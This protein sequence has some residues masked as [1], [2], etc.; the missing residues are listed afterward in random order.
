MLEREQAESALRE[1]EEKLRSVVEVAY[2]S[3]MTLDLH[4]RI[5]YTNRPPEEL[6]LG[7]LA[8]ASIFDAAK[9]SHHDFLRARLEETIATGENATFE[10]AGLPSGSRE[11]W[12]DCRI[13]PVYRSGE[14]AELTMLLQYV[15]ARKEAEIILH[16]S[17]E[18]L[19]HIVEQRTAALE[20]AVSERERHAIQLH[21]LQRVREEMWKM[22]HTNEIASV[23]AAIREGLQDIDL[24]FDDC[25][26][27]MVNA[28]ADPPIV[29][30]FTIGSEQQLTEY[31]DSHHT[32]IGIWKNGRTVYRS[33]MH[34]EDRLAEH[35]AIES[36]N[37]HPIYSMIDLPFSH[38]T[39]SINSTETEA[40]SPS[41]IAFLEEM[42]QILSEV[43]KRLD[44]M[45]L[46]EQ[47]TLALESEVEERQRAEEELKRSLG[48]KEI[49]LQE[50]HHRVKNNMQI[51]S[52][53]I[54]LQ[55]RQTT[56]EQTLELF[57]DSR[58]RIRSMALVHE[59]LYQ[60][61]DLAR[62]DLPNYIRTLNTDLFFSYTVS[63][64]KIQHRIEVDEIALG[65]DMAIPCGLVINELV[66][67]ALK[68]AFPDDRQGTVL[69]ELRCGEYDSYALAVRDDGI[70]LP[71]DF[72]IR[73]SNSLGMTLV[74]TLVRQ[75]RGE[76]TINRENGT[77]FDIT[78]SQLPS[79]A[80]L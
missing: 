51:V 71:A 74:Q 21:A 28:T 46:M 55:S 24:T 6:N 35:Q 68:Y 52:S 23:L 77:S 15:T 65:I 31:Q 62:I 37:D 76:L 26:I 18:E 72:D 70:G 4:G 7:H 48:D 10:I 34:R 9:E 58:D 75:L 61:N 19:E 36:N 12:F 41:D 2:D 17:R 39:L 47:H 22:Q 73:R 27:N 20:R 49:L 38:G 67:N 25:G 3:I 16:R 44:D 45:R 30:T 32:V 33:N 79:A 64:E 40:F 57:R 59:L 63:N 8:S 42:A 14:I 60:S 80:L 43:F 78:F 13:A 54:D 53:L 69:V 56:D 11:V 5:L 66:S 1:S 29:R 50:I